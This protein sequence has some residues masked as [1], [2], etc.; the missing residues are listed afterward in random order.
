M[1]HGSPPMGE[2]G[3]YAFNISSV[4]GPCTISGFTMTGHQPGDMSM[5]NWTIR[6]SNSNVKIAGNVFVANY[7]H[8]VVRVEG[9]SSSVIENNLF[10]ANRA[11]SI[12]ILDGA[13][14]TIEGNTFSANVWD[15]QISV[16]GSSSH[17]VIRRNMIV[18]G[19]AACTPGPYCHSYGINALS[20]SGNVVI[21][22]NDVWNNAS[23]NYGGTLVDQTGSNGNISQDPL[24][25]G[26]AGSGNF[27]LRSGSPCAELNVPAFCTGQRM[28]CFPVLCTVGT[29]EESWG[30]IKSLFGGNKE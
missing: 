3:S 8:H 27:Y 14:A 7:P 16:E 30:S 10:A 15:A 17:A 11:T 24:F 5:N 19:T 4:P 28:G 21:E 20:P 12:S 29:K 6:V 1:N 25:C 13:S 22:C 9:S 26:V 2:T 23:G 18:N